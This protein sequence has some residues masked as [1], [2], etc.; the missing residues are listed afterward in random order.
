MLSTCGYI[1]LLESH[2][3]ILMDEFAVFMHMCLCTC[4]FV[5]EF[6]CVPV[7]VCV[8]DFNVYVS[9]YVAGREEH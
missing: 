5:L 7:C 1:S 8:E 2:G 6:M 9:V 3:C 4:L